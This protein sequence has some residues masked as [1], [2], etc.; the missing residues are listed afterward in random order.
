MKYDDFLAGV[1]RVLDR[2]KYPYR[3]RDVDEFVNGCWWGERRSGAVVR[4]AEMFKEWALWRLSR[5][6]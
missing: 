4:V 6:A 3:E 5:R 2:M 1:K